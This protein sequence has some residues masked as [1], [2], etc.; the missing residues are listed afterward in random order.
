[1]ARTDLRIAVDDRGELYFTTKQDGW[2]R[3]VLPLF[4]GD[5]DRDADVDGDDL[6]QWQ[7]D[8]GLN[9]NSDANGDGSSAGEDFLIWQR[10]FGSGLSALAAAQVVPEPASGLL[11][12]TMVVLGSHCR[13]RRRP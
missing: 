10:Q 2:I 7:G 4:A 13:G 3:E 9:G 5:F 6:A 12:A 1:V 11:L 8:Y